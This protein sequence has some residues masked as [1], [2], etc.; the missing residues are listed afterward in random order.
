[1][2]PHVLWSRGPE[3]GVVTPVSVVPYRPRGKTACRLEGADVVIHPVPFRLGETFHLL[4]VGC[5]K[6]HIRFHCARQAA[7]EDRT[8]AEGGSGGACTHTCCG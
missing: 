5:G 4:R 2:H 1:M 3:R 7:R 6:Q 8:Q